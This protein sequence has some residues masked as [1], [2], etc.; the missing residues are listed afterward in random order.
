MRNIT[1]NIL[2]YRDFEKE[3]KT[4]AKSDGGTHDRTV[5][6]AYGYVPH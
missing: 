6:H 4:C 3:S 5:V 2:W 1:V